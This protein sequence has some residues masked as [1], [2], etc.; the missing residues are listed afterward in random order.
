MDR[1]DPLARLRDRLADGGGDVAGA[2][3]FFAPGR[4]NLLGAHL[5]YNGGRVMPV[6]LSRGTYLAV[7]PRDDDSLVLES[8]G[9]PGE[10]VETSWSALR[11][12]RTTG[13]SAYL[14]G[15]LWAASRRWG[16]PPGWEVRVVADLPLA[17]GVS[18]SASI[19]CAAVL[20][21]ASWQR[22][23]EPRETLAAVAHQGETEYV[24][25]PCG[26]LDQ[27]AIFLGREDHVLSYDC[28]EGTHDYLPLDHH[29][30]AVVVLDSGTSRELAAGAFEERVADC[31]RAL[32]ALRGPLPGLR[33][34]R[35]LTEEQLLEHGALLDERLRRRAAH[36][37]GEVRR[38]RLGAE[39]LAHGDLVSF[40]RQITASHASLRDLYEVST[41][42][43]DALVEAAVAAPGCFGARLTGAGFGGCVVALVDPA[44]RTDFD[45]VV[46]RAYRAAT[47]HHPAPTWF[48]PAGGARELPFRA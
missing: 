35:D 37:V 8:E 29:R 24:G 4:A 5:D 42:E 19:A 18:S 45:A 38:T 43:L 12:G 16:R 17:K 33:A 11:P 6:A 40:G 15:A 20:A 7:A 25:V 3:A 47:G 21:V 26:I 41:P 9:F 34:L 32:E 36:V 46:T 27:T 10:R 23:E 48:A 44:A 13:W 22:V 30:A 1:A 31:R 14:E 2:R 39:A 28:L